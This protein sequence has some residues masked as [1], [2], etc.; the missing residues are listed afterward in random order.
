MAEAVRYLPCL[1]SEAHIIFLASN[2]YY[3]NSGTVKALYYYDPLDVK[4]AN[5][6]MKK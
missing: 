6:I 3:V 2:I 1:G 5:P 4:G